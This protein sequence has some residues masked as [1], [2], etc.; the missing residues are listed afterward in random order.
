M[1]LKILIG[2]IMISPLSYGQAVSDAF[3]NA[4]KRIDK[5]LLDQGDRRDFKLQFFDQMKKLNDLSQTLLDLEDLNGSKSPIIEFATGSPLSNHKNFFYHKN[6][7]GRLL[8]CPGTISTNQSDKTFLENAA[9]GSCRNSAIVGPMAGTLTAR[10]NNDIISQFSVLTSDE[11]AKEIYKSISS[12]RN[13]ARIVSK[14]L[15]NKTLRGSTY[16][17]KE[18]RQEIISRSKSGAILEVDE[19]FFQSLQLQNLNLRLLSFNNKTGD[20]LY[21]MRIVVKTSTGPLQSCDTGIY[22][23]YTKTSVS[24]YSTFYIDDVLPFNCVN[25]PVH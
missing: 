18:E 7:R 15:L 23:S 20:S 1:R 13:L 11:Q 2:L 21:N 9:I 8:E 10:Q 24:G 14:I 4:G 3:Y 5:M 6:D 19:A 12:K 25:V 16:I 17:P 22:H